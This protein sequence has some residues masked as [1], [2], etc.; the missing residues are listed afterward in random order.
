VRQWELDRLKLSRRSEGDSGASWEPGERG[1]LYGV[2]VSAIASYAVAMNQQRQEAVLL[3]EDN[4]ELRGALAELLRLDGYRVREARNGAHALRVLVDEEVRPFAIVLDLTMPAVDGWEFRRALT[5][6]PDYA[7]V[8][9]VVI[10]A[11]D[12][13][14]ARRAGL[15][16][17]EY[18]RKPFE[19]ETLLV[20][21]ARLHP[22][23]S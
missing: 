23:D 19:L 1:L 18:L 7:D 22:H 12:E 4:D 9:V 10:S 21:L 14:V 5:D 15:A 17:V 6:L 3:V 8:P 11:V 2:V 20:I 16:A 13:D